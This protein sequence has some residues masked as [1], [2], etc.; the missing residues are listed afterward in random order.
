[1]FDDRNITSTSIARLQ[2]ARSP[3]Q[4]NPAFFHLGFVGCI[5]A[6]TEWRLRCCIPNTIAFIGRCET[7]AAAEEEEDADDWKIEAA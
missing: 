2:H 7:T 3:Q 6:T 1:V 5:I 4:K